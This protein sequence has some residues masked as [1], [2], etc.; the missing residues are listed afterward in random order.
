M[1]GCS[2]QRRIHHWCH[3]IGNGA[4]NELLQL[5]RRPTHHHAGTVSIVPISTSRYGRIIAVVSVI[6]QWTR[7]ARHRGS[8]SA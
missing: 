2:S 8:A 6:A 1:S 3:S 7:T 5:Q 4:L